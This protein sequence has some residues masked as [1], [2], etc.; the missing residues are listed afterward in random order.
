[1]ASER[2]TNRELN[3]M[4]EEL[5]AQLRALRVEMRMAVDADDQA[6]IERQL[7]RVHR[8]IVNLHDCR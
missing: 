6:D 7:D 1:M 8:K 5:Q 2:E 3:A 4:I